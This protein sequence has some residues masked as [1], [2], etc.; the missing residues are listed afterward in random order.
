MR[1]IVATRDRVAPLTLR[2]KPEQVY[3]DRGAGLQPRHDPSARKDD[4]NA[5]FD[6]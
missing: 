1:R 3:P 2:R 6:R 4:R 5:A